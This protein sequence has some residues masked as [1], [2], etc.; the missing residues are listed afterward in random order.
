MVCFNGSTF[1][2]WFL[3]VTRRSN[4]RHGVIQRL[5][6]VP[7]NRADG[8]YSTGHRSNNASKYIR[9]I[10]IAFSIFNGILIFSFLICCVFRLKLGY[11]CPGTMELTPGTIAGR[12]A[13]CHCPP[14]TAQDRDTSSSVCYKLYEQGPC[15][16][17]RYFSPV[18]EPSSKAI[19]Y[20]KTN[21]TVA[22]HSS[23]QC[24]HH[25]SIPFQTKE[26]MGLLSNA[27]WMS[28]RNGLLAT[29]FQ[30]LYIT[31]ERTVSKRQTLCDGQ[32]SSRRVQGNRFV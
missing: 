11:P 1:L 27:A 18:N 30:M 29:R 9:W 2:R 17:G 10:T 14:G 20:V 23:V 8:S 16:V 12:S 31:Y 19:M 5:I 26:A 21:E 13:E 32:K 6:L 7:A 24:A 22:I 4:H 15:D 28:W 25:Q 3:S